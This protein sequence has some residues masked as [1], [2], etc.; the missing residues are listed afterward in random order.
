MNDYTLLALLST[1][2]ATLQERKNLLSLSIVESDQETN[3][4]SVYLIIGN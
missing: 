1:P 2:S 4:W 3:A